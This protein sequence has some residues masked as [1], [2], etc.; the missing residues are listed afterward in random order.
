[1]AGILLFLFLLGV[2]LTCVLAIV[3]LPVMAIGFHYW[4]GNWKLADAR[5]RAFVQPR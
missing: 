1:L 3:L 2:L 5:R 4:K